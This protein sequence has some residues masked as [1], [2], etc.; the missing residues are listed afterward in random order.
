MGSDEDQ[1]MTVSGHRN[2]VRPTR[3]RIASLKERFCVAIFLNQR[4]VVCALAW[5]VP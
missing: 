2:L 1:P 5:R 3:A 4:T